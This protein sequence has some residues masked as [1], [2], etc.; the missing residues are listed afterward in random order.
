MQSL[1]SVS[2]TVS[3]QD[4]LYDNSVADKILITK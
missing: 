2:P 4:L 1:V 3:E